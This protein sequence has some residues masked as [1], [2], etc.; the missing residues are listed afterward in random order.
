M[1]K[2]S[3]LFMLLLA[4]FFVTTFTSCK[5]DDDN[6]EIN[7]EISD[8]DPQVVAR[9]VIPEGVHLDKITFTGIL[10]KYDLS[11][12][13]GR[14]TVNPFR[15]GNEGVE[16]NYKNYD[17]SGYR[18]VNGEPVPGAEII[19][20]QEQVD[21][22]SYSATTDPDNGSFILTLL[23]PGPGVWVIKCTE[24]A[25]ISNGGFAVLGFKAD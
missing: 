2:T 14:I 19:I 25:L 6:D 7:I 22:D 15:I 20:E 23:N 18:S 8:K 12:D 10:Y 11:A 5:K 21:P 9:F 4:A 16:G 13:D 24:E 17:N 1:K 3:F